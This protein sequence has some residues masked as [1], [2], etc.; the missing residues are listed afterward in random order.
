MINDQQINSIDF[1]KALADETRQEI[2]SI[3]CC[4]KVS[5][6]EIAEKLAVSQPTVSH[7]LKVLKDANLV[8]AERQG[9]QVFYSVNQVQM[10]QACCKLSQDFAPDLP[11]SLENSET[12]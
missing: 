1:A 4:T 8:S 9:K 2:M 5:V 7:H 3:C 6:N 11:I 10:A 12:I